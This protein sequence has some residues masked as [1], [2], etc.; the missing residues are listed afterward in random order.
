MVRRLIVPACA[1]LALLSGV[2]WAQAPTQN[3]TKS[4]QSNKGM[5]A[6]KAIWV[7]RNAVNSATVLGLVSAPSSAR[8]FDTAGTRKAAFISSLRCVIRPGS[9]PAG[10]NTPF[11]SQVSNPGSTSA[12]P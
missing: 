11:H 8:R 12:M 1:S 3:G 9:V 6:K 2:A 7:S 10:A 5:S 4:D